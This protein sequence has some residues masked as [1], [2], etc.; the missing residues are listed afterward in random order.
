MSNHSH[1]SLVIGYHDDGAAH[2]WS[3]HRDAHLLVTGAVG[4]G[5]TELV[6]ALAVEATSIGWSVRAAGRRSDW[7]DG[8][9]AILDNGPDDIVAQVE[10]AYDEMVRRY[11]ASSTYLD[12]PNEDQPI[13]IILDEF[14]TLLEN[15]TERDGRTTAEAKKRHVRQMVSSILREG[16]YARVHLAVTAQNPQA[17]NLTVWPFD[18][19]VV[20]GPID[21]TA[22][23]PLFGVASHNPTPTRPGTGLAADHADPWPRPITVK[24]WSQG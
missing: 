5:K 12:R 17:G 19:R 9:G 18:A 20:M 22:S 2:R 15:T 13:L 16:R 7:S 6:K 24:R 23:L 21:P 14:E 4:S 11:H 3:P 1:E 10:N 8:C